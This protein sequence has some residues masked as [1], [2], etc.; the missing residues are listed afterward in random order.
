MRL[1]ASLGIT[2]NMLTTSGTLLNAGAAVVLTFGHLRLG[3][4]LVITGG[5][6]DLLDGALAR[7]M[8]KQSQFGRLLDSTFDRYSDIL[9]LLGLLVFFSGWNS[10]PARVTDSIACAL[11]IVG[12]FLVPYVRAKAESLGTD[13]DIGFAGRAERVI[14][15]AAGLVL[16]W[17]ILALWIL[18]ILTHLTVA[19]RLLYSKS[20]LQA[21]PQ[22][23]NPGKKT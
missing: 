7:V 5:L 6:C 18:A 11:V 13:C 15:F 14:I 10:V 16:E 9:P 2:P 3:G 4:V 1:L 12:S 20:R 23:S 19:Q 22:A 21:E 8:D 17:E